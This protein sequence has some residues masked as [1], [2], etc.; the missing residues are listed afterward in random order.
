MDFFQSSFLM[1]RDCLFSASHLDNTGL[2][3]IQFRYIPDRKSCYCFITYC[4]F[5]SSS[6]WIHYWSI[7]NHFNCFAFNCCDGQGKIKP[8]SLIHYHMHILPGFFSIS[9]HGNC[10][11]IASYW[12]IEENIASVTSSNCTQLKF[13]YEY[14][15][16]WQWI[17]I[18]ISDFSTNGSICPCQNK[19]QHANR[20]DKNDMV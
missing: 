9:H 20:K 7:S 5:F 1:V 8:Y 12:N 3:R 15:R 16:P 4:Y 14:L 11:I 2:K 19:R 18:C 13:L 17:P 6:P 10:Y